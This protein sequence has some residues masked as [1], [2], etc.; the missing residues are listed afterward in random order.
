M[1]Y[2]LGTDIIEIKR[3]FKAIDRHGNRFIEHLFTESEIHYCKKYQDPIPHFAGRFAAKEAILKALGTGLKS[4]ISWHDI[5]IK[6]DANGK[7][8]IYLSEKLKKLFP[9]LAIYLSISHCETYA[10]ATAIAEEV[11]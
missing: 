7:P 1:I 6:N 9:K 10:T 11:K 5:E 2:G 8:Q 4:P 3:I